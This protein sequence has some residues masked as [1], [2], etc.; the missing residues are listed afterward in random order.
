M[1]YILDALRKADAERETGAVPD[2]HAQQY[3]TMPADDEGA[4]RSGWLIA[5]VGLLCI[6]LIGVLTWAL[7]ARNE[8]TRAAERQTAAI[9][10]VV[11]ASKPVDASTPQTVGGSAPK[12]ATPSKTKPSAALTSTPPP[13]KA[14][15]AGDTAANPIATNKKSTASQASTAEPPSRD[16]PPPPPGNATATSTRPADAAA[17]RSAGRVYTWPELPENIRKELPPVTVNGSSYSA[18]AASR[19]LIAN[20]QVLHEG[21]KLTADVRLETIGPRSA[22]LSFRGYRYEIRY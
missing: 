9:A 20:G 14:A 18:Q 8:A 11:P 1:S 10:P 13:H 16:A 6:A 19:L 2:L 5:L 15:R 21:D 3:I 12:V 4:Q 7:L 22:V 17:D